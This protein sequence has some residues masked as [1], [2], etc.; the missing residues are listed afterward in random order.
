MKSNNKDSGND[1]PKGLAQ[2]ALR[3]LHSAG[4]TELEHLTQVTEADLS[5][6]HGMGPKAIETLRD[7]LR[8]RGLSFRDMFFSV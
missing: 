2:P 8:E 3:A 7:A 6:L 4:L 5:K 1:F